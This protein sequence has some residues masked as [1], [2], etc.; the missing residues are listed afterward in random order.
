MVG[1]FSANFHFCVN[2]SLKVL[3]STFSLS[4]WGGGGGGG[5]GGAINLKH[6]DSL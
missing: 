2:C 6:V 4:L 5:G 3:T 1:T